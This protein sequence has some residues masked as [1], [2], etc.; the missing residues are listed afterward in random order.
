VPGASPTP[1]TPVGSLPQLA[2]RVEEASALEHAAA[3]TLRFGLRIDAPDGERIRSILLHTQVQIAA[4]RRRHE[5]AEEDRLFELF[6]ERERWGST[7]RTLP[8]LRTTQVVPGF[9]G[10]TTLDLEVPCTYD[11]DVAASR[12]LHALEDGEVPLELLF[13]GTVFYA[14]ASGLLQTAQ[15]AWDREAEYALPVAVWRD[16]MERYFPGTAW[17]RLRSSTFDRLHAYR[18]RN[19]LTSWEDAI[20]SLLDGKDG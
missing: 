15:I 16:T 11:F 13:S 6:G 9:T 20:D 17:L 2:F 4:R 10:T 5:P 8:W 18:S 3:P 7:L 1:V 14:G 12:Y 19:A